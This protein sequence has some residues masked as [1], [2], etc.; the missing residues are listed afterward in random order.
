[1]KQ[2]HPCGSSV[3]DE[4]ATRAPSKGKLSKNLPPGSFPVSDERNSFEENR[5]LQIKSV[6]L[7]VG[8]LLI[9]A[10]FTCGILLYL[11]DNVP[12]Q[13]ITLSKD[14]LELSVGHNEK[15][16]CVVH[17]EKA[18]NSDI[19]WESS[20]P[21]VALVDVFGCIYAVSSGECIVTASSGMAKKSV[22]VKVTY[23][24]DLWFCYR[25]YCRSLWA[26]SA[27]DGS[28]LRINTHPY[29]RADII[30]FTAYEAISDVNK[31]LGLPTS[32]FAEMKKARTADGIQTKRFDS[33]TVR[34]YCQIKRGLNVLYELNPT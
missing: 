13:N 26:K 32:L 24:H 31:Q 2:C 15:I 6:L 11:Q 22:R 4:A 3:Q 9:T 19:Q 17:P 28:F 33:V 10:I 30:D 8:I 18:S 29:E 25:R 5:D 1:M 34:W 14:V 21:R 12:V 27:A 20:D 16:H 23:D 7:T